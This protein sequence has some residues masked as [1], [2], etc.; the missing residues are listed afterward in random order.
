LSMR[1]SDANYKE[2]ASPPRGHAHFPQMRTTLNKFIES[3]MLGSAPPPALLGGVVGV[4]W[5]GRIGKD[6]KGGG[7]SKKCVGDSVTCL[8]PF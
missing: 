1:F 8:I 5:G 6:A 7:Q 2:N 4:T 3:L